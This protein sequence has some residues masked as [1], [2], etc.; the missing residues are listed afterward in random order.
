[1]AILQL[2]EKGVISMLY[3]KWWKNTGETCKRDT[4]RNKEDKA[5][6]LGVDNVGSYTVEA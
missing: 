2:Q 4:N 6:A 1:L 5:S 3:N